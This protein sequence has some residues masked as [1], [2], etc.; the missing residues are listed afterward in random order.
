MLSRQ[1]T[2][3]LSSMN[4]RTQMQLRLQQTVEGLSVLA[5]SYYAVG[6]IGYMTKPFV[7]VDPQFDAPIFLG[8]IAPVVVAI[9][10]YC[11]RR[12]R[13]AVS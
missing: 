4:M 13:R 6:I 12:M 5:I 8:V 1:N 11:V 7:H 3:L 2:A 9:V 10:W